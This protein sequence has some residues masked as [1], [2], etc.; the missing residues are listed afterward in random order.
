MTSVDV[1]LSLSY[2]SRETSNTRY[3]RHG[4][5]K[6]LVKTEGAIKTLGT[7]DTEQRQ[8]KQITQ[9]NTKTMGNTDYQSK[10]GSYLVSPLITQ[11]SINYLTGKR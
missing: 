2:I 1:D 11:Q 8:T 9:H 6:P 7:H 5:K 4:T 3:T 10:A